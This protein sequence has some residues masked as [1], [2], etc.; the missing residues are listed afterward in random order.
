MIKEIVRDI[1]F[2][3]KP[4]EKA[5]SIEEVKDIIVDM[6]DTARFHTD[7]CLGMAANQIGSTKRVVVVKITEKDFIT[8]INPVIVKESTQWYVA[9]ESCMSLDGERKVMRKRWVDIM[10]RDAAFKIKKMHC[11]GLVAQIVQHEIDHL[12]G[13]I[14]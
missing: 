4:L 3:E 9:T 14:I 11:T 8:M 13:V 12:N 6:L 2:L 1:D 5:E 7:R 10:Y